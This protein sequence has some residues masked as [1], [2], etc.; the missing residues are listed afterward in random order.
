MPTF[1]TE[2]RDVPRRGPL[3]RR[4]KRGF[5]FHHLGLINK[6]KIIVTRSIDSV[7]HVTANTR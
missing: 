4:H 1:R 2:F 5:N 7:P 3:G 6:A